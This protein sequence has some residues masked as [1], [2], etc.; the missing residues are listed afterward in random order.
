MSRPAHRNRCAVQLLLDHDDGP[1]CP[2]QA[3]RRDLRPLS[4]PVLKARALA[5]RP[6]FPKSPSRVPVGNTPVSAEASISATTVFSWEKS[7]SRPARPRLAAW[8][9][10]YPDTRRDD[11]AY[12]R[13]RSLEWGAAPAGPAG[14]GSP[15]APL[16]GDQDMLPQLKDHCAGC[17]TSAPARQIWRLLAAAE[18]PLRPLVR[19]AL[20]V[21][22]AAAAFRQASRPPTG[23]AWPLP[24][25]ATS[26]ARLVVRSS[27]R[28]SLEI[29]LPP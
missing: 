7:P 11:A 19:Y 24:P 16:P 15:G 5:G 14:D 23:S 17:S 29:H 10:Q 6:G 12:W 28:E 3:A 2:A 22:Q 9:K 20:A 8:L 21:H 25:T 4:E 27:R 26:G 1:A 18:E 13:V